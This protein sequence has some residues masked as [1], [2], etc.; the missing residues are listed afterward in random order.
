MEPAQQEVRERIRQRYERVGGLL[1]DA[2]IGE[3]TAN[4]AFLES[5]PEFGSSLYSVVE[6]GHVPRMALAAS[7]GCGVPNRGASLS[8]GDHVI[9]LGCG[10]GIDVLLASQ[11]VGPNGFV[12]GLDLSP[13]M[14][15]VARAN[16]LSARSPSVLLVAGVMEH[17]PFRASAFDVVISNSSVNLAVDKAAVLTEASR[18]LRPG[19]TLSLTDVVAD[20]SLDIVERLGRAHLTGAT[21]GAL[22]RAEYIDLLGLA[23]FAGIELTMSHEVADRM[24]ATRISAH[25]PH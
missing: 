18:V 11:E 25:L 4:P 22:S 23:G 6:R 3:F 13:A 16:V 20:D 5:G 17:L 7:L 14:L 19:G 21:V 10:G 12:V 9:D 15:A 1:W 24:S 8:P 2:E